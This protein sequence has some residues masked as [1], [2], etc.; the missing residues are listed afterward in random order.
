MFFLVVASPLTWIDPI[1]GFERHG[2]AIEHTASC[3]QFG[4][5]NRLYTCDLLLFPLHES[6]FSR[7]LGIA[8]LKPCLYKLLA[9]TWGR[10]HHTVK[11]VNIGTCWF[12]RQGLHGQ[13]RPVEGADP[14]ENQTSVWRVFKPVWCQYFMRMLL[15]EHT[16]RCAACGKRIFRFKGMNS[17]DSLVWRMRAMG[18]PKAGLS[19]AW[20]KFCK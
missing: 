16:S 18:C 1:S 3:V 11:H 9:R 17:L 20:I 13:K 15:L 5:I 14:A 4:K 10:S 12:R 6:Y 19:Q 7:V 2:K 8:G